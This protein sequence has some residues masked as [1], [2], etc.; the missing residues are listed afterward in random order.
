MP[1]RSRLRMPNSCASAGSGGVGPAPGAGH[2][3]TRLVGSCPDFLNQRI[4]SSADTK[5]SI[6]SAGATTAEYRATT[7]CFAGIQRYPGT[8]NR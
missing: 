2:P 1:E 8:P 5:P 3:G 6:E 4:E 7:F